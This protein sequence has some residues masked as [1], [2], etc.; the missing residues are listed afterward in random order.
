[1][2]FDKFTWV[3]LMI[4]ALGWTLLLSSPQLIELLQVSPA[5]PAFTGTCQQSRNARF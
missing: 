3:G 1:M 2:I 4:T 5:G